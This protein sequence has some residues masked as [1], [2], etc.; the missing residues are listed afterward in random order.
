MCW[1][2]Q[3]LSSDAESSDCE[4]E[5][6][7]VCLLRGIF[8]GNE[9]KLEERRGYNAIK[10]MSRMLVQ[11]SVGVYNRQMSVSELMMLRLKKEAFPDTTKVYMLICYDNEMIGMNDSID[12]WNSM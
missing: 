3:D 9:E 10:K 5:E 2:S 7:H 8:K 6:L 1:C 4:R 11:R 12:T